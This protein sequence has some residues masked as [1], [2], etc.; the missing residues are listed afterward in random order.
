M[1]TKARILA[2]VHLDGAVYYPNQVVELPVATAK[3]L[4][5]QGQVDLHKDAISY[6]INS[7]KAEVVVHAAPA[8]V[9]PAPTSG[10]AAAP[11]PAAE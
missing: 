2:T 11:E 7:L 1:G 5:E 8:A 10:E 3:S 4:A 6:C 9:P